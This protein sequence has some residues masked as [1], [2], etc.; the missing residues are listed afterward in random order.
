MRVLTTGLWVVWL[1]TQGVAQ[2]PAELRD[3][4]PPSDALVVDGDRLVWRAADGDG[5]TILGVEDEHARIALGSDDL[6]GASDVELRVHRDVFTRDAATTL[7]AFA[8]LL[9]VAR[10]AALDVSSLELRHALLIGLH[11][12]SETT[13]VVPEGIMTAV[14]EERRERAADVATLES[15]ARA[16]ICLLYT[17]D[18]ADE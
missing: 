8:Q 16:L 6:G 4:L 3:R 15:R 2:S 5:R 10:A 13:F 7:P 18:A 17:S 11:L 12:R 9:D 1:L 14:E